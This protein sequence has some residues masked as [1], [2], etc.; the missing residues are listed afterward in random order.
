MFSTWNDKHILKNTNKNPP[1]RLG[2]VT[3]HKNQR[4]SKTLNIP[5][6]LGKLKS[7]CDLQNKRNVSLFFQRKIKFPSY[8]NQKENILKKG[9]ISHLEYSRPYLSG[10]H[11]NY[12]DRVSRLMTDPI[13]AKSTTLPGPP[14]IFKSWDTSKIT[15]QSPDAL[16]KMYGPLQ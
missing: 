13:P 8:F 4:V 9:G 15:D 12:L 6:N 16:L 14:I 1:R 3:S 5:Y 10:S 7:K 11:P 2:L